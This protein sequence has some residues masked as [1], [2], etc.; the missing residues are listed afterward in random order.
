MIR[1]IYVTPFVST[2]TP[3]D[4]MNILKSNDDL[5]HIVPNI[6]CTKLASERKKVSFV[7]FKLDVPRHHYDIIVNPAIWRTNG[8]D[9][10]TV[11]DFIDKRAIVNGTK[12]ATKENPFSKPN[13][14]QNRYNNN[15]KPSKKGKSTGKGGKRPP[16]NAG[17]QEF[18]N[19]QHFWPIQWFNRAMPNWMPNFNG[20]QNHYEGNRYGRRPPN[21]R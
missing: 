19:F 11:K 20:S 5:K 12:V 8:K 18:Q 3:A 14:A 6:V 7:S 9:E 4:I 21:Q 10:I 1:S 2:A 15:I 17:D 16:K 13:G